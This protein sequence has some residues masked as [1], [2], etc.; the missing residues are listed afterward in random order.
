MKRIVCWCWNQCKLFNSF[1]YIKDFV[2]TDCSPL[3]D[4]FGHLYAYGIN[5][6]KIVYFCLTLEDF[7]S[8]SAVNLKFSEYKLSFV[9]NVSH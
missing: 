7:S 6:G 8:A 5:F 2:L 1:L 4:Q 3:S 9:Q